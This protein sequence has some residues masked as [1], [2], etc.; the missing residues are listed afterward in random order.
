MTLSNADYIFVNGKWV[1][2][3]EALVPV[4]D[5]GYQLADGVYEVVRVYGGRAF[6]L[7]PH[8]DRLARSAAELEM[9]LPLTLDEVGALV[10]EAPGRR[11][12]ED[13]QVYI[14]VT[15]GAAPRVHHFPEDARPSL[16]VY[17]SPLRRQPAALYE[18]GADAVVVPDE[19]W[20]RCD[21]KSI[22]LLP[23]ALAKERARRAGALE[24]LLL[25]EG[26]GMT[27][28]SSSNL[29]IVRDGR[30][31]TAPASR[32]ILRGITRDI[33]LELAAQAHI[34]AAER[35]FSKEE[36]LS[37]DEA[38][39]TSTTMEVM[40]L[41][42]VD[43]QAIGAGRPGPVTKTLMAAFRERVRAEIG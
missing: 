41:A 5:R 38:F 11:G 4:E 25:R 31:E 6:A 28:G 30:L 8:L 27:E 34:P 35:F 7:Q 24:A 43:G 21:I 12:V 40:P 1:G 17:A 9:D 36:L 26:V 13:G 2:P 32:W 18:T 29:F 10:K 33:V 20:L 14:Q 42:R 22:N 37:A 39:V 3:G 16:V 15:R 19:R 23:N